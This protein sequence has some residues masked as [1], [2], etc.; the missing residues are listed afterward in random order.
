MRYLTSSYPDQLL[1]NTAY[2]SYAYR[3]LRLLTF[4]VKYPISHNFSDFQLCNVMLLD[5]R[6]PICASNGDSG[7]VD[8][9][10]ISGHLSKTCVI[11]DA[12]ILVHRTASFPGAV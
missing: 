5:H 4:L 6:F 3:H 12:R 10:F 7:G 11:K 1:L 9:P 8:S 2:I